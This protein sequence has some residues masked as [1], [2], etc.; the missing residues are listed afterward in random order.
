MD[1][2]SEVFQPL[3]PSNALDTLPPSAHIGS[4]ADG[5]AAPMAAPMGSKKVAAGE[6]PEIGAVLNLDEFEVCLQQ[7][8]RSTLPC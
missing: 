2:N 1:W 5:V 4:L 7:R 3:H 8:A 6:R